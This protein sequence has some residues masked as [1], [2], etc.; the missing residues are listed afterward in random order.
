MKAGTRKA[1]LLV[2]FWVVHYAASLFA[3]AMMIVAP[4]HP[5][6]FT[7][8]QYLVSGALLF[9]ILWLT[10]SM[11]YWLLLTAIN[12]ALWAIAIFWLGNFVVAMWHSM[13]QRREVAGQLRR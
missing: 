6:D 13:K 3:F 11:S 5:N 9:P 7:D 10:S 12:S 8:I 2:C 1:L 4:L